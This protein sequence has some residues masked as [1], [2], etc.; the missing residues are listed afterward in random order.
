MGLAKL[1]DGTDDGREAVGWWDGEPAI[2]LEKLLRTSPNTTIFHE[3][4][5]KMFCDLA[6]QFFPEQRRMKGMDMM[7]RIGM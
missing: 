6:T 1:S 7:G 3:A 2:L 5:G 4:D